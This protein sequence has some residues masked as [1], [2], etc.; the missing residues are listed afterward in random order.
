[1]MITLEPAQKLRRLSAHAPVSAS[2]G[3]C[4]TSL[5]PGLTS[6]GANAPRTS[7]TFPTGRLRMGGAEDCGRRAKVMAAQLRRPTA[8]RAGPFAVPAE[9]DRRRAMLN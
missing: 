1:M 2:G 8:L 4:I 5:E 6:T 3:I 9:T 7:R